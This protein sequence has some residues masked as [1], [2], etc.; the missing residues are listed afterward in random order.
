MVHW[1]FEFLWGF[2]EQRQELNLSRHCSLLYMCPFVISEVP[3]VNTPSGVFL[4][5]S[6]SLLLLPTLLKNPLSKTS[7]P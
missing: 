3:L 1:K 2:G 6:T 5:P 4:T 7:H